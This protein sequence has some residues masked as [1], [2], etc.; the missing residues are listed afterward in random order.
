MPSTKKFLSKIQSGDD[1][2]YLLC[3]LHDDGEEGFD[4]ALSDGAKAWTGKGIGI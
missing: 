1:D 4:V 2:F 3:T